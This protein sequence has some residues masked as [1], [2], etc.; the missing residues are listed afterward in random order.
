MKNHVFF[1][2]LTHWH[3][4]LVAWYLLRGC[5]VYVFDFSYRLKTMGWLRRLILEEKVERIYTRFS[6]ADGMAI[7]AAEWLYPRFA[8]HPV[9]RSLGAL[10]GQEEAEAV[11]KSALTEELVPYLFIQL[12]F[13]RGTPEGRVTLI[14]ESVQR[15]GPLFQGWRGHPDG[16]LADIAQPYWLARASRLLISLKRIVWHGVRYLGLALYAAYGGLAGA[17]PGRW[18]RRTPSESFTYLYSIATTFQMKRGGTRRFD[19]LLDGQRLTRENTAFLVE[20]GLD[21]R[22]ADSVR[23]EG[24]ALFR[25]EDLSSPRR[26]LVDPPRLPWARIWRAA[27]CGLGR[28][29]AGS[30]LHEASVRGLKT[31]IRE[32]PL[33][34]RVRFQHYLYTNQYGLLPRWRNV[35]LRRAG[36]QSWWFAYSTGGG[37]LY[38][39]EG[40]LNGDNDY[41]GRHHYWAYQNADHFVSPCAP[42]IAYHREH[43]QRVRF[44]H[45]VGNLWSERI[46]EEVRVQPRDALRR[47]WF[48]EQAQGRKVVAWFDTTFVEAPN[49]P[50]TFTE[51]V[52]WYRDILRLTEERPDLLM[53]IKPSKDEAYFVSEE[54]GQQWSAPRKGR[55]V[56]RAWRELQEHPRVRF[57]P[58]S[59]DPNRVIAGA[60]LT[61]TFCF[62][63]VSSE[64]LA[65]RKKGI[66]YEPGERWRR[67]FWGRE[68]LLTAHGYEELR[69][70]VGKLLDEMGET[71]YE[72]FL[73]R[74]ARGTVDSFLD[75]KGLSRF[76]ALLAGASVRT[77]ESPDFAPAAV[78]GVPAAGA[79]ARR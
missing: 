53:V 64:A 33:L 27:V 1:E 44:Y 63:S 34:E 16:G 2:S 23:S 31:L 56:L 58:N 68:P 32:T 4:P 28:L 22:W 12:H 73:E 14:S 71:E 20:A 72:Q 26:L 36:I 29:A 15:W 19:F 25:M 11:F 18:G 66:W 10:F 38:W 60:D 48:G 76:R 55:E 70:L 9:I 75:G 49:S 61:V 52:Q 79:G 54:A 41:G 67:T 24:Y 21:R 51:A 57:L 37:F 69:R 50:S 42:L 13:Q 47:S 5:R 77:A 74:S 65:A 46:L 43:R 6:R 7:D 30:W 39:E 59:E 8:D 78:A 40:A 62:S 35:L 3:R 45:D 17:W